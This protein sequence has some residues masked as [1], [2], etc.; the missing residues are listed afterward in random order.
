MMIVHESIFIQKSTHFPS[1]II[2]IN[3]PS[4]IPIQ[5]DYIW[6]E[7]ID[8]KKKF[9][10]ESQMTHRNHFKIHHDTNIK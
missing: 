9:E 3:Q 4:I 7:G 8:L 6:I 1:S 5:L 2:G 10:E